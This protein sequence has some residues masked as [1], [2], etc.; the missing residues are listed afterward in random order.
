VPLHR[1]PRCGG[2]VKIIACIE[3]QDI[4]DRIRGQKG[5]HSDLVDYY[6]KVRS[7][8]LAVELQSNFD[9]G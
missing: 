5:Y 7:W 2:S 3:D 9:E 6:R 1:P 8:G 4:I